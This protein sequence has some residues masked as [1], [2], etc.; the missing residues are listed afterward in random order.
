MV[1]P[2]RRRARAL[3]RLKA[4]RVFAS[5]RCALTVSFSL[6]ARTL[7]MV[8]PVRLATAAPGGVHHSPPARQ[9]AAPRELE[10]SHDPGRAITITTSLDHGPQ[11]QDRPHH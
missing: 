8:A 10:W 9:S 7:A 6:V 11:R 2:A 5:P 3:L 4:S 1:N